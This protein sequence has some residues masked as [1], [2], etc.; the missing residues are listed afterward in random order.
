MSQSD[1]DK[2]SW[3]GSDEGNKLK[4]M[5]SSSWTTSNVNIY[6]VWGNN[7]S[8]FSAL[9]GSCRMFNG[10]WGIPEPA[11]L[12]SGGHQLGIIMSLVPLFGLPEIECIQVL[13][14]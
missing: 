14:T 1:A 9:A 8:G 12:D 5:N 13:W 11:P 2:I 10:L 4:Q 3:R 7:E 6:E